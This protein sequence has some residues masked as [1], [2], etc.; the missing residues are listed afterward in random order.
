M[1]DILNR[2]RIPKHSNKKEVD[3]QSQK[4]NSIVILWMDGSRSVFRSCS[5]FYEFNPNQIPTKPRQTSQASNRGTTKLQ[6]KS[7]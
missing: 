5:I 6:H 1:I 3:F 7:N 2:H 4:V